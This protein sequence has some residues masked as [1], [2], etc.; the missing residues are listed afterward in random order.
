MNIFDKSLQVELI[1]Q[2]GWLLYFFGSMTLN[3][4]ADAIGREV[5]SKVALM[6]KYSNTSIYEPEKDAKKRMD[7]SS[8]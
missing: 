4:L 2:I 1:S 5:G 7:R 8:H 3:V 6:F